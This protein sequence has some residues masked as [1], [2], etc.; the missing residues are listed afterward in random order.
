MEFVAKSFPTPEERVQRWFLAPVNSL[1]TLD[2]DDGAFAALSISMSLYERLIHSQMH[3]QNPPANPSDFDSFAAND[4]GI[5]SFTFD[6]FWGMYR[7]GIQ[8]FFQPFQFES[9]GAQY[10]W[11][12]CPSDKA[13]PE[14]GFCVD[15]SDLCSVHINPWEFAKLVGQKILKNPQ[16]LNEL[17]EYPAGKVTPTKFSYEQFFKDL[18]SFGNRM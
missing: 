3:S 4:L 17:F 11:A 10:C 16:L 5:S 9:E 2:N 12:M 8:H 1:A 14:L 7:F 18:D 6:K 13:V 15:R